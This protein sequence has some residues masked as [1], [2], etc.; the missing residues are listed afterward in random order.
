M[1]CIGN[2]GKS[3]AAPIIGDN[4]DIGVWA[5]IIGCVRIGNNVKIGANAVVFKD[6]QSNCT[7]VGN[8]MRI[9]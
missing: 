3:L 2:N 5:K 1:N 6:V 9:I 8:L 7:V 4:V